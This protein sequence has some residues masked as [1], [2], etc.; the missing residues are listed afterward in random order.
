LSWANLCIYLVWLRAYAF[1]GVAHIKGVKPGAGDGLNGSMRGRVCI[2]TGANSG[3]G[4]AAALELAKLG[5]SLVM[6]CRNKERG[7]AARREIRQAT[8][9]ESVD[10]LI[11]DMASLQSVRQLAAEFLEKYSTLHVLINNAGV[12]NLR[13]HVTVDGYERTFAVNY[14]APFLL[15]NLLLARLK[16]SAPSRVVN[17]SSV[18]HYGGHIDFDDLQ[19]RKRYGVMKAYGRSKLALILFT[20]ELADR[21][22]G[23]GV[24]ANSMHPGTVGTNI[25]VRPAGPAGFI[26]RIPMLFMATPAQGAETVVHLASSPEVE[27]TSGEYFERKKS[28]KSSKVSYNPAIAKRL[29]DVSM[30]L[31]GLVL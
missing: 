30:R 4:K 18:S 27:K 10:L 12:V 29:W 1:C 5:F 17:V 25:W 15:T 13:R 21:I 9:D 28:K 14:L 2:I 20:R 24:T 3:I 6:V 23:S 11:A 31:T 22:A 7:E 19:C 26:M 16:A 8:G